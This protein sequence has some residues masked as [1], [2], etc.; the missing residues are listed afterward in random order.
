[1]S[2]SQINIQ[3][4]QVYHFFGI[5]SFTIKASELERFATEGI[6]GTLD[7]KDLNDLTP[8]GGTTPYPPS[9]GGNIDDIGES[10]R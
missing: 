3:L 10:W 1:M 8:R 5:N 4:G 7:D 2:G 9:N 6:C